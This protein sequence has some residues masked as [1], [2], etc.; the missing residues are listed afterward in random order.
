VQ[1]DV[2]S[3]LAAIDDAES[4]DGRVFYTN[5]ARFRQ[6]RIQSAVEMLLIDEQMRQAIFQRSDADLAVALSAIGDL[7]GREGIWYD[8]FRSW[9]HTAVGEFIARNLPPEPDKAAR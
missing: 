5:F 3:N 1:F 4:I 9:E 8:G 2:L 7:A 6:S